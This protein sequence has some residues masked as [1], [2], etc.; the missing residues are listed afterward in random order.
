MKLIIF[1]ATG[2]TGQQ[3]VEQALAAGHEVTV[4]AR[5]GGVMSRA[6]VVTG[7]VLDRATVADAIIGHDAVLSAL[8]TRPHSRRGPWNVHVDICSGGIAS[9]IPAMQSAGVKRVIAMSSQGVGDSKLDKLGTLGA[10]LL[11]GKTFRDK[12]AM[13]V[14]LADSDREW[15]VVRPGMLVNSKARGRFRCDVDG[16]IEGGKICRADV[17][18]F[19]LQQLESDEWLRKRPVLVW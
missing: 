19:M 9:M 16:T 15:V 3:L 14:M 18:A 10:S 12:L 2:G 17:A 11:L 5:Q 4:F 7:D 13:E 6:R 8:G 1:G